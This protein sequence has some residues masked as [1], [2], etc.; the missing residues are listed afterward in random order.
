MKKTLENT[1]VYEDLIKL[2]LSEVL[3]PATSHHNTIVSTFVHMTK[4][5]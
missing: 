4:M 2:F 3:N 1:Q 5:L